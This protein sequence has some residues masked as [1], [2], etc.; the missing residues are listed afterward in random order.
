MGNPRPDLQG[1]ADRESE[2]GW[3]QRA[4]DRVRARQHEQRRHN[5]RSSGLYLFFDDPFRVALDAAAEDR[6]ISLTGYLRR[7]AAAFIAYDLGLPLEEVAKHG[8]R[9]APYGG[10][11]GGRKVRTHDDGLGF[12]P[13]DIT[14]LEE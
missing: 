1:W 9:P 11:G 10:S 6:G 2:P 14:G 13:W 4:I 8:A 5:E 3:Q 7:S 12:G